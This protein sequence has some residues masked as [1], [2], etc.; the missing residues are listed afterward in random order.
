MARLIHISDLHFGRTRSEL[1]R[2]LIDLLNGLK[3]DL[4]AISG[5]LTQRAR[6]SQF[7]A[8]RAF[9]DRLEP[10][11]L[12]VPGNHD[13]PLDA[14]LTRMFFPFQ[15]YRRWIAHELEPHFENGEIIVTGMNTVN[16]YAWQ[17]GRVGSRALRRVC[18]AFASECRRVRVVVAHHPFEHRPTDAK[19]LMKGAERAIEA[20]ADCGADIIL[21]G[22][23][24]SWRAEPFAERVGRRGALQV[25]AGTGLSTRLRGE[26]NDFNVLTVHPGEIRVDRY[27]AGHGAET[28]GHVQRA[29]FRSGPRG[30]TAAGGDTMPADAPR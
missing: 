18:A 5:D 17:S 23:L 30:W 8:A 10:P 26:E 14:P 22:H 9:I 21:T 28:F 15:R 7:R 6:S 3:A 24:H 4:V 11:V 20:L 1:L 12:A 13:V 19:V 29:V 16:P 2:P 27:A 25:H